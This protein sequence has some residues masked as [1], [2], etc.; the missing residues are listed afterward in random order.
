M[1]LTD[2]DKEIEAWL[3]G[4][5]PAPDQP[6]APPV[7]DAALGQLDAEI[8]EWLKGGTTTAKPTTPVDPSAGTALP[9]EAAPRRNS[10]V[11]VFGDP[12]PATPMYYTD[13]AMA[14]EY[15]EQVQRVYT[16]ANEA[17]SRGRS[18]RFA[19]SG[20]AADTPD[21][22]RALTLTALA[23]LS[24]KRGEYAEK[25]I[26]GKVATAAKRGAERFKSATDQTL[27]EAV[28]MVFGKGKPGLGMTEEEQ[29]KLDEQRES[30]RLYE[31][32]LERAAESGDPLVDPNDPFWQRWTTQAA[33]M[34]PAMAAGAV[35]GN[36]WV[37]TGIWFAPIYDDARD[38]LLEAGVDPELARS[39]GAASAAVQAV[40]ET[41]NLNPFKAAKGRDPLTAGIRDWVKRYAKAWGK[42][43]SEEFVQ[44]GIQGATVAAATAMDEAA[45]DQGL[46]D[47]LKEKMA[48]AMS[49]GG[50]LA[51]MM[52]PGFIGG[53]P[54]SARA[55]MARRWMANTPQERVERVAAKAAEGKPISRQDAPEVKDAAGRASL[56][57]EVV[58]EKPKYRWNPK[59]GKLEPKS[60]A[61]KPPAEGYG[62][63]ELANPGL[64][65]GARDLVDSIDQRRKEAGVP[66]VENQEQV[67][68][69]AAQ[70]LAND[71]EG[72][73][74]KVLDGAESPGAINTAVASQA[75]NTE[76]VKGL[77]GDVNALALAERLGNEY[78]ERRTEVGRELAMGFDPMLTP[79]QRLGAVAKLATELPPKAKQ[80]VERLRKPVKQAR[81]QRIQVEADIDDAWRRLGAAFGGQLGANNVEALAEAAKA[82]GDLLVAY[83]R[84]GIY[85]V[86][87]VIADLETK[88]ELR[89]GEDV[90]EALENAAK[91][92]KVVIR[93]ERTK[94][95]SEKEKKRNERL[96]RN[97]QAI[98]KEIS[99]HA[100]RIG[101]YKR[102]L[103]ALKG[104]DLDNVSGLDAVEAA[105]AIAYLQSHIGGN[106]QKFLEWQRFALLSAVDTQSVNTQGNLSTAAYV[107]GLQYPVQTAIKAARGE[108]NPLE[109]RAVFRNLLNRQKLRNAFRTAWRAWKNEVDVFEI[110]N[111]P[112]PRLYGSDYHGRGVYIR[113]RKGTILRTIGGQRQLLAVDNFFK[114]FTMNAFVAM[115]AHRI[116]VDEG[117]DYKKEGAAYDARVQDLMNNRASPAWEAANHLVH[118]ITFQEGSALMDK[119]NEIRGGRYALI[120][121]ALLPFVT[122]PWNLIRFGLKMTP[123]VGTVG[124]AMDFKSGNTRRITKGLAQQVIG[125]AIWLLLAAYNDPYDEDAYFR[126]TGSKHS[127]YRN[128]KLT[129]T[130]RSKPFHV[131]IGDM[132]FD[133]SRFDPWATVFGV[134]VDTVED[135]KRAKNADDVARAVNTYGASIARAVNDKTFLITIADIMEMAGRLGDGQGFNAVLTW[136]RSFAVSRT[137]PNIWRSISRDVDPYQRDVRI[138]GEGWDRVKRAAESARI[139]AGF[140]TKNDTWVY[141]LWGAP[142][143]MTELDDAPLTDGA[144]RVLDFAYRQMSPYPGNEQKPFVGTE[145]LMRWNTDNPDDA[146]WPSDPRVSY[147]GKGDEKVYMNPQ[148]K[149]QFLRLSGLMARARVLE[150]ERGK[151][152]NPIDKL[153]ISDRDRI[154]RIISNSRSS[155]KRRLAMEWRNGKE[156]SDRVVA[157]EYD[158][159]IP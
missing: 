88:R 3:A 12:A 134:A 118:E 131:Y 90:R 113:G 73:V 20:L 49:A 122:T 153:K 100:K 152:F 105:T 101:R 8:G 28:E 102:E 11:P 39:A 99:K 47:Q 115:E 136:A 21:E 65:Q 94:N 117:Y 148:Q 75:F 13:K 84:K 46:G 23:Q 98:K 68:A 10:R 103:K 130:S 109:I 135:I 34:T 151:Q 59:T 156:V 30:D 4:E 27:S 76:A 6:E 18:R 32:A 71:Y 44:G 72:E 116:A 43:L 86:Q 114:A 31:K 29:R 80:R 154:K 141:D 119:V 123:G 125:G 42:E 85:N 48:D 2:L 51:V 62:R 33:E 139:M 37:A 17:L 35:T 26:I 87:D 145:I 138:W 1:P 36:P 60:D 16:K 67:R 89:L 133:Y 143:S 69:A 57:D 128:K 82:A 93:Q 121:Q 7:E 157:N 5:S 50:P 120:A 24:A 83:A 19:W 149:A 146:Y 81:K 64:T 158:F 137:V 111:N 126:I 53:L 41:F 22:D 104:I 127:Q 132:S 38:E 95:E 55:S 140:D 112:N 63:P 97:E 91:Q 52:L 110:E 15:G 108:A 61:I 9:P 45:P 78:R 40:V 56:G 142:V 107:F 25:G 124:L 54:G 66:G 70:R 129:D 77:Q 147:K 58:K 74:R 144:Y 79:E 155:I 150:A 14:G 92:K 106:A 96:E 159:P